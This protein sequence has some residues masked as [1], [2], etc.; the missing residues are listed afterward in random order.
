MGEYAGRNVPGIKEV[1]TATY[2]ADNRQA[3]VT[4][5]VSGMLR[6]ETLELAGVDMNNRFGVDPAHG[7]Q[8]QLAVT[9]VPVNLGNTIQQVPA[10]QAAPVYAPQQPVYAPQHSDLSSSERLSR[11]WNGFSPCAN[12]V[13]QSSGKPRKDC[14][15]WHWSTDGKCVCTQ[16]YACQLR[17][18]HRRLPALEEAASPP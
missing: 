12:C 18:R 8:K 15:K 4:S 17:L 3:D 5:Q 6:G 14:R 9:Y 11:K 2:G 10:W 1:V 7:V 13:C 16:C